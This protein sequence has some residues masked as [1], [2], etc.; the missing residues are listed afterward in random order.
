MTI[1]WP[2][3]DHNMVIIW[4]QYD[5]HMTIIW[6]QYDHHMHHNMHN[7][8]HIRPALLLWL[9][10]GFSLVFP[11][12]P[13]CFPGSSLCFFFGFS[14]CFLGFSAFSF[15]FFEVQD[16]PGA[17]P[18][19]LLFII[20]INYRFFAV[21]AQWWADPSQ[22]V[23]CNPNLSWP[24]SRGR[25]KKSLDPVCTL[26]GIIIIIIISSASLCYYHYYHD[27]HYYHYYMHYY[28]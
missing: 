24:Q 17:S 22:I 3:Y 11:G 8:G 16:L 1:I 4:P 6:P 15:V 26:L 25:L 12:F 5:H 21:L 14:L 27:Y 23:G 2:Q 18:G 9:F 28:H 19:V 7:N 10:L 13:L 20:I